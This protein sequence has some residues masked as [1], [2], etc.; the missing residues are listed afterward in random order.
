MSESCDVIFPADTVTD[1]DT[2]DLSV[3]TLRP[4]RRHADPVDT[5]MTDMAENT[6]TDTVPAWDTDPD[7]VDTD[8]VLGMVGMVTDLDTVDTAMT[9][10]MVVDTA[11]IRYPNIWSLTTLRSDRAYI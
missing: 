1:T 5:D 6:P 4:T 9:R 10:T 8:T 2:A 3:D 7:M 11:I